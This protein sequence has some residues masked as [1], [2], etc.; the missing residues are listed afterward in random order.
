MSSRAT[1]KPH[2]CYREPCGTRYQGSGLVN[3][4]NG[5]RSKPRAQPGILC[6]GL[7]PGAGIR[8]IV[9]AGQWILCA[10][11]RPG[12]GIR[13]I[14]RAGQWILCAGL[15]PG[16]GFG[17]SFGRVSGSCAS[18]RARAQLEAQDRIGRLPDSAA[19]GPVAVALAHKW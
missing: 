13:P 3:E 14:V 7:R 6:A 1:A 10:G 15:R 9:R 18:S 5:R 4:L 8:P 12:A 11:L 2:P 17:P 19:S 16:A